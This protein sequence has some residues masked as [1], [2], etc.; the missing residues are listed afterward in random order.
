MK[1]KTFNINLQSA[2]DSFRQSPDSHPT[3]GRQSSVNRPWVSRAPQGLSSVGRLSFT[4]ALRNLCVSFA[5]RSRL[6]ATLLLL[7]TMSVGQVWGRNINVYCKMDHNWW[8]KD[9]ATIGYKTST[10]G[11]MVKMTSVGSNTFKATNVPQGSKIYFYRTGTNGTDDWGA[12]TIELTVP[13]DGK[14]L[15]TISNTTDTWAGNSNYCNGSWSTKYDPEMLSIEGVE[16]TSTYS[17]YRIHMWSPEADARFYTTNKE[18]YY[19]ASSSTGWNMTTL[20][21]FGFQWTDNDGSSWSWKGGGGKTATKDSW[22]EG[23]YNNIDGT[24]P[25]SGIVYAIYFYYDGS[26]SA[27][28][29][30]TVSSCDKT[31]V[32]TM[33]A[34]VADAVK[35][36]AKSISVTNTSN[37]DTYAWSCTSSNAANVSFSAPTS[38]TTNFTATAAGTYAVKMT[39]TSD[40]GNTTEKTCTIT[41]NNPAANNI[42]IYY[43]NPGKWSKVYYHIWKNSGSPQTTWE[44]CPE[45]TETVVRNCQTYYKVTFDVANYNRIL[46]KNA[47]GDPSSQTNDL[48]VVAA[49]NGQYNNAGASQSGSWADLPTNTTFSVTCASGIGYTVTNLQKGGAAYTS[50]TSDVICGDVITFTVNPTSGYEITSVKVAG[51][52]VDHT[53]ANYTYATNGTSDVTIAIVA[54]RNI[55]DGELYLL[56]NCTRNQ[57]GWNK[58]AAEEF[59]AK[60]NGVYEIEDIYFTHKYANGYG[61]GFKLTTAKAWDP[62]FVSVAENTEITTTGTYDLMYE[63]GAGNDHKFVTHA[64]GH[65]KLV[66][67]FTSRTA[68]TIQALPVIPNTLGICGPLITG[69]SG[70]DEGWDRAENM[71]S[72]VVSGNL[73]TFTYEKSLTEGN[74][75]FCLCKDASNPND[76]YLHANQ[77]SLSSTDCSLVDNN[78]GSVATDNAWRN[79]KLTV[80]S[81]GKYRITVTYNTSN[82]TVSVNASKGVAQKRTATF[83]PIT[84]CTDMGSVKVYA[85]TNGHGDDASETWSSE[86]LTS[87][88]TNNLTEYMCYRFVPEPKS[89]YEFVRWYQDEAGETSVDDG[90]TANPYT[91][92]MITYDINMYAKFQVATYTVT[93]NTN[94]GTI[95]A[96]NVTNYKFGTGATLPTDVTR[97]HY[98]FAGWY[99]NESCTGEKVTTIAADATGNKTFWA[100]WV[101]NYYLNGTLA[102]PEGTYDGTAKWG[103]DGIAMEWNAD[104]TVATKTITLNSESGDYTMNIYNGSFYM[105]SANISRASNSTTLTEA[106]GGDSKIAADGVGSYTFTYTVSTNTLT[107]TYPEKESNDLYVYLRS[108]ITL[109]AGEWVSNY[110]DIVIADGKLT[111]N[112]LGDY[113]VMRGA[114]VV[115]VHVY[116]YYIKHP[117]NTSGDASKW[118]WKAM[119]IKNGVPTYTGVAGGNN[120]ANIGW[121]TA[122]MDGQ[123]GDID[124]SKWFP[125]VEYSGDLVLGTTYNFIYEPGQALNGA[126][127]PVNTGRLRVEEVAVEKTTIT[128]GVK[129]VDADDETISGP[130]GTVTST[131]GESG[132]AVVRE[133]NVTFTAAAEDGYN[134]VGWYSEAA[135]TNKLGNEASYTA[136]MTGETFAIYAKF[137]QKRQVTAAWYLIGSGNLG[138]CWNTTCRD[139][140]MDKAYR[141][142]PDMYYRKVTFATGEQY[143]RVHNG[144]NQF[145]FSNVTAPDN[146][147]IQV[148]YQRAI[149]MENIDD[150]GDRRNFKHGAGN[151]IIV[152]LD[153]RVVGQPKMWYEYEEMTT[154]YNVAVTNA[155]GGSYVLAVNSGANVGLGTTKFAGDEKYLLTITPNDGKEP[156][157]TVDGNKVSVVLTNEGTYTYKGEIG[158]ADHAIN[159]TY[160]EK[161]ALTVN[162]HV[163]CDSWKTKSIYARYETSTGWETSSAMP[164][165]GGYDD[166]YTITYPKDY[167]GGRIQFTTNASSENKEDW[168]G[169]V[170][171]APTDESFCYKVE[172][173]KNGYGEYKLSPTD[174][175][176]FAIKLVVANGDEIGSTA[177]LT[178]QANVTGDVTKHYYYSKDGAAFVEIAEVAG[179]YTYKVVK[180]GT[181]KYKV[182][183]TYDGVTIEDISSEIVVKPATLSITPSTTAI[184]TDAP[185]TLTPTIENIAAGTIVTLCLT[186]TKD[187][188]ATGIDVNEN[189]GVYSIS[190]TETGTY[191]IHAELKMGED[192]EGDV[193]AT[194]ETEITRGTMSITLSSDNYA[195]VLDETITL[196]TTVNGASATNYRLTVKSSTEPMPKIIYNGN[197]N[198]KTFKIESVDTYD[199]TVTA[200]IDG[201]NYTA[202]CRVVAGAKDVYINYPWDGKAMPTDDKKIKMTYAGDGV[203]TYYEEDHS[204]FQ[205]GIEIE[206]KAADSDFK[207]G[208]KVRFTYNSSTG[209]LVVSKDDDLN[210][211]DVNVGTNDPGS[212]G[213][214]YLKFP[215]NGDGIWKYREMID[216]GGGNYHYD[217]ILGNCSGVN[218]HYNYPESYM[219]W[220]DMYTKSKSL[221]AYI[222][223]PKRW[224]DNVTLIGL[225]VGENEGKDAIF[226]YNSNRN[227]LTIMA[228]TTTLYRIKSDNGK[229]GTFYSNEVSADD[230]VSFYAS[231]SSVLTMEKFDKNNTSAWVNVADVA[232]TVAEG[233]IYV[234]EA[235]VT[236]HT[237]S[238]VATYTGDYYIYSHNTSLSEATID[239]T[240]ASGKKPAKMTYFNNIS[241]AEFY[242]HYWVE[243]IASG[244]AYATV[245]NKINRNLSVILPAYTLP[246]GTNLRYGFNPNTNYFGRSFL[247]GSGSDFLQ[248][249]G[250]NVFSPDGNTAMNGNGTNRVNFQ[251]GSNWVYTA[252]LTGMKPAEMKLVA[253]YHG[254]EYYLLSPVGDPSYTQ[255]LLGATSTT[256]DE[257]LR[258]MVYYDYKFNR[259]VAGWI[260]RDET[261]TDKRIVESDILFV[262]SEND[263][264]A[265]LV[266]GNEKA[267]VSSL[268]QVM[269]VLEFDGI[270]GG[271]YGE[272]NYWISLPFDCRISDIFGIAGYMDVWGIQRYDGKRRAEIGWFAETYTFWTW[273]GADEILKKG[274]G[275]VLTLDR[276]A[277]TWKDV[278]VDKKTVRKLRLFFPSVE[279]GFYM[280]QSTIEP[281]ITYPNEECTIMTPEDRRAQDSNWKLIGPSGYTDI[282]I[283]RFESQSDKDHHLKV[284]DEAPKFLYEFTPGV[285]TPGIGYYRVCNAQDDKFKY[286]AFFSYMVQF[287]GTINWTQYTK[288]ENG[289]APY[290]AAPRRAE[291]ESIRETML[292]LD[293]YNNQ[294]VRMD[295]TFVDLR[296]DATEGFDQNK[297]LTKI[298]SAAATQI[299]SV[300]ESQA[301]A[302][303]AL[304]LTTDSIALTVNVASTGVYTIGMPS[305]NSEVEPVL[306]DAETKT[307][308]PLN[309]LDYSVE[310]AKGKYENRF[311]IVLGRKSPEVVT[312][313]ENV[314][315]NG[316]NL[317]ND[318]VR[319]LL[320]NG[321]LYMLRDGRLFDATGKAVK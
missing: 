92:H 221:G 174:C 316:M 65:Y 118:V 222:Y 177:T 18:N 46:F 22:V 267:L 27:L 283:S 178:S 255:V 298:V 151:T 143:F 193:I 205:G 159:I 171:I 270:T 191:G 292:T 73:K 115:H 168:S 87:G 4:N 66:V 239:Q 59:T 214:Y 76:Y 246:E 240:P 157:V 211:T 2:C 250:S 122:D 91:Y 79:F 252:E 289:V 19:M 12:R 208:D 63:A 210:P 266:M 150:V 23:V 133:T 281:P 182:V 30:S 15:F 195:P 269:F 110:K 236:S 54:S 312:A 308:T 78:A 109:S 197:S 204:K 194:A 31:P 70:L 62:K 35:N 116:Q 179:A 286:K 20:S 103:D 165:M 117:W 256:G 320:I 11:T 317:P 176:A 56:G 175:P 98:T 140:P 107:V 228:A 57:T 9:G 130:G 303:N 136:T 67:N 112:A 121:S 53:G 219:E 190:F 60:G 295:Q 186:V 125:H 148:G 187:G 83:G 172:Q 167:Q 306:Y 105:G 33:Q 55:Y 279:K 314:D 123:G 3:V 142:M 301:Y 6:V 206:R 89:G 155:A 285:K 248:L 307:S 299:Y 212:N 262:R 44:S 261:I 291:S 318:G 42:T 192:C 72:P 224:V 274:E 93:L 32:F 310:L 113:D 38:A 162:L 37:C 95:N 90:A 185:V 242:N 41:V 96:G 1:T 276:S 229:N 102:S 200:T 300:S 7:V 14:N 254:T 25:N 111:A 134:F 313:V 189:D 139:Y 24:L 251:D 271:T 101:H 304:P 8:T 207:E 196:T 124:D 99:D 277:A 215:W 74:Y 268:Q 237:L 209:K 227:E 311:Y 305:E 161:K 225:T 45:A 145:G 68:G 241:D 81:A 94:K 257:K 48:T 282:Q 153:A 232:N 293:I 247:R 119:P 297:D 97:D 82:N 188:E 220:S 128:F 234:A 158:N 319:K 201:R 199:F 275:Y 39:A 230:Q 315:I 288:G 137:Q 249:F 290:F 294:N 231:P 223:E 49:N 154:L 233:N 147:W 217:A 28:Y 84:S 104:F 156:E 265:Q 184:S 302:G 36:V 253:N 138:D 141:E 164:A 85:R 263:G 216:D 77:A 52:D 226:S 183:A 21:G 149:A 50:G 244:D 163:E 144:V 127:A 61:D 160:V 181:Y 132:S 64:E 106:K 245:G 203:Y 129:T 202:S 26:N 17:K 5:H 180:A 120:G 152:V 260:P 287:G 278:E 273:M 88:E 280:S 47:T 135:C 146:T 259:L 243:W 114:S 100:K 238:N 69:A 131:A 198:T 218:F 309:M 321:Q 58:N 51:T 258:F 235:N 10:S 43:S 86:S 40:C 71:S 108:Q 284:Q 170:T 169:Q 80:T 166:W 16:A 173:D 29:L 75:M 213:K 264:I 296:K 34:D 126:T 272:S 13:S